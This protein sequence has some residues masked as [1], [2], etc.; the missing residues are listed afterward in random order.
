MRL[1]MPLNRIIAGVGQFFGGTATN[2]SGFD[3]G[4]RRKL[5]L[6]RRAKEAGRFAVVVLEADLSAS[7]V[8]DYAVGAVVPGGEDSAGGTVS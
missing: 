4:N 2:R 7:V 3:I 8:P 5:R 1:K 6:D